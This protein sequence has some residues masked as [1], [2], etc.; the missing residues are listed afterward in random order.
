LHSTTPAPSFFGIDSVAIVAV[1][2]L[3]SA[4]QELPS[5]IAAEAIGSMPDA[6]V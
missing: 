5:E 3:P 1:G 4:S 6:I 2:P